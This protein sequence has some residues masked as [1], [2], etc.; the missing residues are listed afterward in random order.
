[1][2]FLAYQTGALH[3]LE[4]FAST[5]IF[6]NKVKIKNTK[7]KFSRTDDY[8]RTG[9]NMRFSQKVMIFSAYP[10]LLYLFLVE[11]DRIPL[12]TQFM[13]KLAFELPN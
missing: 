9:T 6:S 13:K 11:R 2:L 7:N 5:R 12:L 1:M 8:A 4:S 3:I 10:K